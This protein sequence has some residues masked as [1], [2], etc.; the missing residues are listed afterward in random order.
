MDTIIITIIIIAIVVIAGIYFIQQ[1][2]LQ[3]LQS[4]GYSYGSVCKCGPNCKCGPMCKCGPNCACSTGTNQESL[5]PQIQLNRVLNFIRGINQKPVIPQEET[6]Q[7]PVQSTPT[8]CPTYTSKP[9]SKLTDDICKQCETSFK[10]FDPSAS[11]LPGIGL[12]SQNNGVCTIIHG[13][14]PGSTKLKINGLESSSPLANAALFTTECTQGKTLNLYEMML[15][16]G[17]S[18][19]PGNKSNAELYSEE[20]NR[21]GINVAGQHWHWWAS[22]PYVAAIHHQNVGMNPVEFVNKTTNALT[23]YRNRMGKM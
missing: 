3:Q 17:I 18:S 19:V 11:V 15:P 16:E 9:C 14:G 12:P 6:N 13:M 1:Q 10:K 22:D 7:K 2:Q 4:E 21:A 5:I 23:N 20:L 8:N